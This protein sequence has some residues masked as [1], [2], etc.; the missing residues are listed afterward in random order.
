MVMEVLPN[1][2]DF[3]YENAV[4]E[5]SIAVGDFN[6]DNRVDVIIG[7]EYSGDIYVLLGIGDGTFKKPPIFSSANLSYPFSIVVGDLNGDG[8]L[9]MVSNN[10]DQSNIDTMIGNGNGNGTF[11]KQTTY[12]TGNFSYPWSVALGDF[13]NDLRLDIAVINAGISN[14][15]ILIGNGDG[16]FQEQTT[17]S[18]GAYSFP[19]SIAVADLNNDHQLDIA[20]VDLEGHSVDVFIG[21][22]DGTF[23]TKTTY[24][25]GVYNN[26]TSIVIGDING[27]THLDIAVTNDDT[28]S[29]G[30]FFS[31]GNGTFQSQ[32]Q[33]S[34]G[35]DNSYPKSLHISDFNGDNRMDFA[36]IDI[37]AQNVIV[38]FNTCECCNNTPIL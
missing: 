26:P 21:N 34:I 33:F 10:I 32:I 27:D 23:G 28:H 17:F 1:R 38:L 13:N 4:D 5:T 24:S 29:V 18:I 8:L 16:T 31:N 2:T 35:T 30:V 3:T 7:S 22:G 36:L 20:I 19:G 14:I 9:D 12:S 15:E 6:N 11:G 37:L 25:T